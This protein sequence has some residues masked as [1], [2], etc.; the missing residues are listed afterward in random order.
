MN[1]LER[2]TQEVEAAKIEAAAKREQV[3]ARLRQEA[4]EI[5]ALLE[6]ID[7]YNKRHGPITPGMNTRVRVKWHD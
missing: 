2:K 1:F 3:L 4:P 6:A 5:V 7:D